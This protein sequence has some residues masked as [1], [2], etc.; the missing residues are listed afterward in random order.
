MR[1]GSRLA[2]RTPS[3]RVLRLARFDSREQVDEL[4]LQGWARPI[5]A[6]DDIGGT[7]AA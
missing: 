3:C 2:R 5:H 4:L 1:R 6:V 7:H